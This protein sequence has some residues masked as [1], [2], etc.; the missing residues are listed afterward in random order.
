LGVGAF[1]G[2]TDGTTDGALDGTLDGTTDGT[3][4]GTSGG[5]SDGAIRGSSPRHAPTRP[6][7]GRRARGAQLRKMS[8]E[9]TSVTER[10]ISAMENAQATALYTLPFTWS[11][12]TWGSLMIFST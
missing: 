3:L 6:G 1:D 5:T 12:I 4:D 9:S 11:P 8:G 2:T 10:P 7:L